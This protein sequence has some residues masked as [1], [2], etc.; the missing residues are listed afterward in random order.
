MIDHHDILIWIAGINEYNIE[1]VGRV[2]AGLA[3]HWTNAPTY[4]EEELL[5][6]LKKGDDST[7]RS[8]KDVE[9][10]VRPLVVTGETKA[11]HERVR[12]AVR[13]RISSYRAC[14]RT[15]SS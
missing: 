13:R 4:T 3:M 6:A 7:G 1:I 8:L 11:E 5:P 2:A 12:E 9:L 15:I 10:S 14:G